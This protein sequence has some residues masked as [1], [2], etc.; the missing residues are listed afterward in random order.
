MAELLLRDVSEETV[1]R[2][3][4]RAVA[5]GRS[6]EAEHRAIVDKAA[7]EPLTTEEVADLLAGS[8]VGELDPDELRD[9]TDPGRVFDWP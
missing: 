5:H 6:L 4:R 7:R 1:R 9:R 2:L 8:F 3:E